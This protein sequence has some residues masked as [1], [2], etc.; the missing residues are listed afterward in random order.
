M[1]PAILLVDDEK[2]ICSALNRTFRQHKFTVYQ[3]NTGAQALTLLEKHKVDVVL[4]DQ[5]MP[6][7]KGTELLSIVKYR[8]PKTSRTILSGQSDINDLEAAINDAGICHFLHKPWD[9]KQL[10]NVSG[11]NIPSG[12]NILPVMPQ[13]HKA[14]HRGTSSAMTHTIEDCLNKRNS[15]LEQAIDNNQLALREEQYVSYHQQQTLRYLTI[16][17]PTF[18]RFQ[19]NGLVNIGRQADLEHHLFTW[20]LLN[21]MQYLDAND[22]PGKQWVVDIF[23]KHIMQDS[24][25]VLLLQNVL[26]ER[27]NIILKVPFELIRDQGVDDFLQTAYVSN[28]ALVLNFG[29]RIVE[30]DDLAKTPVRYIEMD[31]SYSSLNNYRLTDKRLSMMGNAKNLE[32]RPI[33][34]KDQDQ[35]QHN[36]V[37][38]MEFDFF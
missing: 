26:K 15:D 12:F 28:N 13:R 16:K 20:Y 36:Y 6:G 19:H 4:S 34:S 2:S 5:K 29:K 30:L 32:I 8:Y 9:E 25:L 3:A 17:W 14:Y 11:A 33:L 21:I 37:R 7:M 22:T 24:S 1:N 23:Y 10:L 35:S 18:S 27:S 38:D 31:S